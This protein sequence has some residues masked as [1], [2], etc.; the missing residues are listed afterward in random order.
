MMSWLSKLIFSALGWKIKGNYDNTIPKKILIV[1]P[2]TSNW[3]FPIGLLVRSIIKDRI[4]FV[5]KDTLFKPP[6]GFI[7]KAIGGIPV[8]R[9]RST[10]F[11]RA[12]VNEY[13]AREKMTIVIAPE[14]SRKKVSKFKTG[15]YFIAKAANIPIV[16]VRFDYGRKEVC[17]DD[18]FY[19]T[20]NSEQDI[21]IIE[22]YFRGI[23]G[24]NIDKSFN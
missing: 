17:F 12:V 9:S 5:G 23:K 3:D 4:Q 6:F 1:A 18:P 2:H 13:N 14:G 20:D 11:V 24:Y 10:N 7:M 16:K 22:D 8:D 19:P 21:K 15:F